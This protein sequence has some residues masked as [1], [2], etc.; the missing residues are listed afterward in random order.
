M[1]GSVPEDI[2]ALVSGR[3]RDSASGFVG[4]I[5]QVGG[6]EFPN[7]A[8]LRES[9]DDPEVDPEVIHSEY[10]YLSK[11]NRAGRTAE[12]LFAEIASRGCCSKAENLRVI[13][14]GAGGGDVA[15]RLSTLAAERALPI[16]ILACDRSPVAVEYAAARSAGRYRT[17]VVD[18]LVPE[19]AVVPASYSVAHCSLVLHHFNDED[20]VRALASMASAASALVIW[21]DLIRDTP[22]IAGAWLSTLLSRPEIRNDAVS[23]VR[24]GFTRSEAQ[25]A[26]EAA[27]LTDIAIRRLS[28]GRFL[29]SGRPGPVP[30]RRPTLRVNRLEVRFGSNWVFRGYS[31]VAHSGQAIT[32]RGPNGAGKSTLLACL[33][34]AVRPSAGSTWCDPTLGRPGFH[35]QDGG[36][37]PDIS[38]AAN[39]EL[40]ARL[41]GVPRAAVAGTV[42]DGLAR[43]GLAEVAGRAVIKL[44]GGMRR[45]VALAAS[46]IHQPKLLL[47]DEPDAG[48]DVEGRSV[49][50]DEIQRVTGSGGTAIMASHSAELPCG[51][52]SSLLELGSC[53]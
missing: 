24:R 15:A 17:K 42:R 10:R 36:V 14:F 47:L 34:G 21:I 7:R 3:F 44:S 8:D 23:S 37:L 50:A 41:A 5:R 46:T 20:V 40:F 26:A 18:V 48:L 49:L 32:L 13:E 9:M 35:P 30:A 45:R 43:W 25:A 28:F 33:A 11:L 16:E 53:S 4:G 51:T 2:F 27:G 39:L 19:H 22:G 1:P 31:M 52:A 29:L 6:P 12:A 38:V